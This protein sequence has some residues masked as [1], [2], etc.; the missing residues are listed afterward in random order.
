MRK[1]AIFLFILVSFAN[2][3]AY[4]L[5]V[6][7]ALEKASRNIVLTM[8]EYPEDALKQGIIGRV[9]FEFGIKSD[10]SAKEIKILESEPPGVFDAAVLKTLESWR[11]MPDPKKGFCN[12][13]TTRSTQQIWFEIEKGAPR[14]SMSKIYDLPPVSPPTQQNIDPKN[15]A[16]ATD[17]GADDNR[18]ILLSNGLFRLKSGSQTGLKFPKRALKEGQQG[19]VAAL[20]DVLPDGKVERATIIYSLPNGVFD[21]TVLKNA[22]GFVVETADGR[23]PGRKFRICQE[24][25]FSISN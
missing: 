22:P 25:T 21:D 2:G 5:D 11:F 17:A 18:M 3:N 9:L 16:V 15:A 12:V 20:Y 13:T 10:G 19:L 1:A 7:E 14:F 24:L 8:P 23:P 6:Q 4:S